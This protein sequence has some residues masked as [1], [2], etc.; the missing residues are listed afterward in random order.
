[1]AKNLLWTLVVVASLS[2]ANPAKAALGWTWDECEQHWGKPL[3][4]ETLSN[5]QFLAE[6][7]AHDLLITVWL[8]DGKVARVSYKDD[9][10][11]FAESQLETFQNANTISPTATWVFT[12]KEESTQN[13]GWDLREDPYK[14]DSVA[15]A[16][17]VV[18]D[19]FFIVFTEEDNERARQAS[20]KN[21][22]DL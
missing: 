6:F 5:G 4:S 13:Y 19:N 1:M 3:S 14:T 10:N 7:E 11:G 20:A 17:Y 16:I 9:G 12:G 22:S 2:L 8:T 15:R 18:K 21:A